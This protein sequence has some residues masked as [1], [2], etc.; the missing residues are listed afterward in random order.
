[1]LKKELIKIGLAALVGL[2]VGLIMA[3]ESDNGSALYMMPLW[4][5]GF[6]YSYQYLFKAVGAILKWFSGVAGFSIGS[7]NGCGF[8]L[9]LGISLLLIGLVV[10]YI[11]I[12]GLALALWSLF[13]GFQQDGLVITFPR[14]SQRNSGGDWDD[15]DDDD[16]DDESVW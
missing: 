12:A 5:I 13:R 3:I 10:S 2:I 14:S 7:T 15:G 9:A 16:D 11:W 6:V 1:M 8:C 4:A